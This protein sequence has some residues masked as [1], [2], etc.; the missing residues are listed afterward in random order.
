[1]ASLRPAR[2]S[3]AV[4]TASTPRRSVKVWRVAR[5]ASAVARACSGAPGLRPARYLR[6]RHAG[7]DPDAG[8]AFKLARQLPRVNT[9]THDQV[10]ENRIAGLRAWR[11]VRA[12]GWSGC[13]GVRLRISRHVRLVSSTTTNKRTGN[14]FGFNAI[15]D[16]ARPDR[17]LRTLHELVPADHRASFRSLSRPRSLAIAVRT[18]RRWATSTPTRSV[19]SG[20]RRNGC[21][22]ATCSTKPRVLRTC[23]NCSKRRPRLPGLSPIRAATTLTGGT[24]SRT[25]TRTPSRPTTLS[26]RSARRDGVIYP[27][28]PPTTRR[29]KRSRSVTRT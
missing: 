13:F 22:S 19:A 9:F 4:S 11:S 21:A 18:I 16:S 28:S 20:L 29:S 24:A 25:S 8:S 7:R 15:Q 14:I 26:R 2:S 6:S 17:R 10:E 1:M 27:A 5:Q 12:A 23:S 3:A